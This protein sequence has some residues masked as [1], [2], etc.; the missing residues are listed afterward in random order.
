MIRVLIVVLAVWAIQRQQEVDPALK[1]AVDR[2]FATQVSEDV[3]GYLALW[4]RTAER[5]QIHQLRSIFDSGDDKFLDL[6]ITRASIDRTTARVRLAV[7]RV[8]T[9][10]NSTNP[11]G[12]P[13]LFSSRQEFSLS[14]ELEEGEWKLVREGSPVDEL[15]ATLIQTNDAAI[16]ATLLQTETDLVTSRLVD[17]IGRRADQFAQ[18]N[19]YRSALGL[20]GRGLEVAR[21]AADRKS[22]GQMLQNIANSHYFLRDLPTA[23]ATYEKR[24][25]LERSVANDDGIASALVGIA[26]ILYSTHDYTPALASYREALA[27]QERLDDEALVATTLISTANVQYLHG[28]FEGA[29]AD[30]RRAEVLKR[31]YH[32]FG[33]AAMALEGLG[34]TYAAQGDYAAALV[35]FSGVL[36]E[37]RRRKDP[38]RQA[39]SSQNIGDT[40]IRLGNLDAA[41][42]SYDESRQAFEKMGDLANAGRVWQGTAV[43]ELLSGR[44]A[45][46]EAAYGKSIAACTS[47][48]PSSDAECIARALVGLGFA[49]AAQEQYEAATQSYRK[50]IAAFEL[51]QGVEAVARA[52][53]GLAEALSGK[54]QYAAAIGEA[55]EARRAAVVLE[56]DDL[57]WRALVA[58][59]RAQRKLG[60]KE[61]SLGAARAAVAAVQ[62][63][64]REAL[65]RPGHAVPR[66]TT[67]AYATAAIL[68]AE[69]GD[70]AAAWTTAEEMRSHALRAAIATNEREI[71]R[72]MTADE[73]AAERKAAAELTALFAQRDR[74]KPLPKP[75]AARLARLDAALKTSTAQRNTS[76]S[77]LFARLPDL[78]AWRGLAPAATLDEINALVDSGAL[79]VQFVLDERDLLV[80]TA[81]SSADGVIHRAHVVAVRRQLV[82]EH[83]A[84]AVDPASL[85]NAETWRKATAGLVKLLPAAVLAQ[86]SAARR[87]I[88]IPDDMLWRVPFEALPAGAGYVGDQSTIHY[89][90]SVTSIVRAPRVVASPAPV[91]VIVPAAPEIASSLLE[92]LKTTAPSWTLRAADAAEKEAAA[93]G[94]ALSE[95]GAV[96]L[97]GT[98]ATEEAVRAGATIATVLHVA[99]PF[100]INAA[101]P[102]FSPILLAPGEPVENVRP[103]QNGMLEAREIPNAEFTTRLVVFSD[104]AALT[105][106]EGAAALPTLQWVLRAGGLESLVVR[107]WAGDEDATTALLKAFYERLRTGNSPAEALHAARADARKAGLPPQVWAGWLLIGLN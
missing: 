71:A 93:V 99:A 83:V 52:R 11:D 28:D 23:L 12:S 47:A 40:H 101:S 50:G 45:P 68:Q 56:A 5:P 13:R 22:E 20:Y 96:V 48:T 94:S 3:D 6:E 92:T 77:E 106:R 57:L 85:S 32:D 69:A 29:I 102:L 65:Q 67:A 31:K 24:L 21:A 105:M 18:R 36:D 8:R 44:F 37:S 1:A 19:E 107:R 91:K 75:D 90:A 16:R 64:A 73:R 53:V 58:Q 55:I 54:E 87:V 76:Q 38:R 79:L 33:G 2:F 15:A 30:Y 104:P 78:R 62:T 103:D 43:T 82:A 26:T 9:V 10:L 4:S 88:L 42:T 66:D 49:Q 46:A 61:E 60:K 95:A 97:T 7:T 25:A 72:G 41:R 80:L 17:A 59:A 63:M 100:R 84:R 89:A 34:R 27:I 14:Y 74:E 81:E 39:S 51:L 86:M 70:A 98:A 35:A